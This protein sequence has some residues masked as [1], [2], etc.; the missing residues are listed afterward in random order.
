MESMKAISRRNRLLGLAF[1]G[2]LCGASVVAAPMVGAATDGTL[3]VTYYQESNYNS[4]KCLDDP[5]GSQATQVAIQ[6]YT[7]NG[8]V[9]QQWAQY[10]TDSGYF[11]LVVAA[12]GQCLEVEGSSQENDHT[13][14]QNIC[15]GG[16][17]QQWTW[18]SSP[19]SPYRL[20]V[21]RHSGK[22]MGV[23]FDSLLNQAK[24]V[25]YTCDGGPSEDWYTS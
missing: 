25:Q 23:L 7:C 18:R 3:A 9:S 6:Q 22:C 4:G 15:N 12:S 17:N 20:L 2:A 14:Q 10:P 13:I 1:A 11:Q 8:T 16:Y 21:A 5:G 19:V 24:V